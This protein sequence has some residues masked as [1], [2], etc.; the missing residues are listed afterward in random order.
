MRF[1][2]GMSGW[3]FPGWRGKFYPKGVPQKEELAYASRQVTSIE[4][5]GTFY[6]FQKPSS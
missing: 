6:R 4:I 2:V 1:R 5:N 3:T